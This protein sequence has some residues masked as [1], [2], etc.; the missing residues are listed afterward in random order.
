MQPAEFKTTW[1]SSDLTKPSEAALAG[2]PLPDATAEFLIQAGLPATAEP[3][4]QFS[5]PSGTIPSL[6]EIRQPPGLPAGELQHLLRIGGSAVTHT[7]I[8]VAGRGR[9]VQVI[10]DEG[11]P[12]VVFINSSVPQLAACLVAYRNIV[13]EALAQEAR[14]TRREVDNAVRRSAQPPAAH[15]EFQRRLLENRDAMR[16]ARKAEE[17][18]ARKTLTNLAEQIRRIDPAA[19]EEDAFWAGTLED[20]AV[21]GGVSLND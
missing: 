12:A 8:D 5:F 17:A 1:G 16:Q 20:M 2:L 14:A 9:V 3:G 18:R 6:A 15:A 7:C 4:F 11:E 19:M 21:M 13:G 10:D